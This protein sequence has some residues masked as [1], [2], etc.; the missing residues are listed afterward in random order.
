MT[1]AEITHALAKSVMSYPSVGSPIGTSQAEIWRQDEDG[2]WRPFEPLT[3]DADSMA[4]VDKMFE[5]KFNVHLERMDGLDWYA[6]FF[7]NP[8]PFVE[9]EHFDTDRCRAVGIAAVKAV[10]AWKE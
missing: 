4:V 3:N 9:G 2:K 5:L 6:G 10:G 7:G 8:E 1:D